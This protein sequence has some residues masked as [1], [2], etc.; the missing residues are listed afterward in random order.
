MPGRRVVIFG[1]AHRVHTQR[2]VAGMTGR[3]F[4]IRLISLGGD[5]LPGVDTF[6]FPHTGKAA[7]LRYMSRAAG[8]ARAFKPDLVHAHYAA[9]FGLW[10]LWTCF[11]PTLVSVWG[12]DIID[13]PSNFLTR[14][15]VKRILHKA[16]GITASSR[17]LKEVVKALVPEA[18]V[19]TTV[20]P[21]GV[22]IPPA[23]HPLPSGPVKI[24]FLKAHR[25]KYGPDI[26]LRAL[27]EVKK[28]IPGVQL[29]MAGEGELTETLKKMTVELDL[30]ENVHFTGYID[31]YRIYDFI[32]QHHF[33]VMP[34]VMESESFGVA[35]LEA[36]ACGR[37][38][39]AS[40][41]GG[42][43]EVI[44]DGRT[45]FFV[46]PHEVGQL[47]EAIIRLAGD[48]ELVAKV[49]R[50]SYEFVKENYN[51]EKS[52]DLMATVYERLIYECKKNPSV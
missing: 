14:A 30:E 23:V 36:G 29:S 41:I 24:C 13:F 17:F 25:K 35:V 16:D 43:P 47:A 31:N 2:W 34:S 48:I 26:L 49:G 10:G 11:K 12:A 6:T 45:G 33:M 52:L 50:A 22:E 42:V 37:P 4:E 3:G 32:R 18:E 9:G 7:Y 21:F 44:V 15:L 1:W 46:T 8:L 20:I 38:T 40:R 5:R 39:I 19:K 51:W 28:K 27:V